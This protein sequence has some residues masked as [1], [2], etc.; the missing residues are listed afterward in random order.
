[1][2]A[3]LAELILA[4]GQRR[5]DERYEQL[6]KVRQSE[7]YTD[8][9]TFSAD[10]VV[11]EEGGF[12]LW[13]G[14]LEDALSLTAL[15]ERGVNAFL[16]CA[17]EECERECSAF[18]VCRGRS[19]C[20]ARGP[21]AMTD[22]FWPRDADGEGREGG[23][24]RTGSLVEEQGL[25]RE[26]VRSLAL[27]DGEWYSSMLGHDTA[28]FGFAADDEPGYPIAGHFAEAVA[29]L[30]RCREERRKVLVHCVMGIN[31]SA[32]ALVAFLC[33]GL[34]MGLAEA[35]ALTSRRRGQILSNSSFLEQLVEEYG[36]EDEC[37]ALD[38]GSP[39][40]Q[41]KCL[42]MAD[43]RREGVCTAETAPCR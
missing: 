14:S 43:F 41:H 12:E 6:A 11:R 13:L 7:E 1:M 15:V 16:N 38:A 20:H 31:R 32:A 3:H 30:E 37:D 8:P 39:S 36:Q 28:Y 9:G 40:L 29:F 23:S 4:N 27:F 17:Q 2:Q 21:S 10:L 35:V 25:S 24:E 42:L 19:R 5:E 22:A 34:G 33:S 18:R 26:Q